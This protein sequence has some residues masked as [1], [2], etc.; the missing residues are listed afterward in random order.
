MKDGKR[1]QRQER[2]T[3]DGIEEGPQGRVARVEREDGSTF[4]L[5][6]A[7]LPEGVREGDVLAVQDG[8]DDVTAQ[9]LPAETRIRRAR[10]QRRLDALNSAA[11]GSE[12]LTL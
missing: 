4:D 7:A 1:A 8:P 2:W 11:E 12:E 10:A 6:L 3:V 5:P 9:V